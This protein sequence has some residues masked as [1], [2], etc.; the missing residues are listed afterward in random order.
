MHLAS[1]RARFIKV[2]DS[3]KPL[4]NTL[5]PILAQDD[6]FCSLSQRAREVFVKIV[7]HYLS[8]GDA[9]GS[10]SLSRFLSI[11]LSPASIRNVMSD[12]EECGLIFAPHVSAGRLPTERGLRFFVD[13]FLEQNEIDSV[14]QQSIEQQLYAKATNDTVEEALYE[15]SN[16]LS[17]LSQCAGVVVTS[18]E[19]IKISQVEFVNLEGNRALVVLVGNNGHVENRLIEL[20]KGMPISSL[21]EATAFLN[22]RLRN[23]TLQELRNELET[24]RFNLE[25][26]LDVMIEHL[27]S[28]GLAFCSKVQG[29][30]RLIIRGFAN[31]LDPVQA[32]SDLNRLRLLFEDLETQK[33][34]IDL[35]A[36]AEEGEGVR[37]FIGSENKLFSLSGSSII[38]APFKNEAQRILGVV[39][40]IGPTRL[41]YGRIIPTVEC[42][43]RAVTKILQDHTHACCRSTS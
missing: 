26:E 14:E 33:D 16:L 20:P 34:V 22:M 5:N 17:A 2:C 15:A 41:N 39:G 19:A 6:L 37:I 10:R 7:E 1:E 29:E 21:K 28:A 11:D 18:K 43:A 42:T 32:R 35:L 40:V 27:I 3:Y 23:V 9:V 31:L 36:R 4:E 13:S 38:T 12:L 30:R 8:T 25:Q 24:S